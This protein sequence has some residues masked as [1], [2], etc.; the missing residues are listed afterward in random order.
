M[1][2]RDSFGTELDV[3]DVI[4]Y[5]TNSGTFRV[6]KVKEILSD[7]VVKL[8]L[9]NMSPHDKI[10]SRRIALHTGSYNWMVCKSHK[11]FEED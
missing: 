6:G 1:Q 5:A 10:K 9:L 2:I 11:I 4:A 8:I 7:N 3:G